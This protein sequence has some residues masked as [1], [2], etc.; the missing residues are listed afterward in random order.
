MRVSDPDSMNGLR[1]EF[2]RASLV[3]GIAVALGRVGSAAETPP[4]LPD[5][6]TTF[7]NG[8]Q[9]LGVA[10]SKLPEKLE[11]LWEL[12]VQDGV[13]STPA[14]LNGRVY[15]GA[16]GGYLMCLELATGK[17]VWKYRSIE[18]TDEKEFAPGFAAPIGLSS[19]LVFA[20][21]DQGM[22][23]VVDAATGKKKW[24]FDA[25]GEIVG[26]PTFIDDRVIFGSHDGKL[27]CFKQ[28]DGTRQWT[29]RRRVR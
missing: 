26:G 20:G 15:V 24:D 11:L 4:A 25:R 29:L 9:L 21:D 10:S 23:H 3:G 8:P 5:S 14:I 17:V 27:F 22:F 2:L 19:G 13:V 7:R 28:A 6:W 1:R 18:S 16:L 12:P